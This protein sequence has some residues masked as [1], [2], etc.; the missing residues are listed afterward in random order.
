LTGDKAAVLIDNWYLQKEVLG[1]IPGQYEKFKLDY[2]RFS[3][4]LCRNIN[5][6]RFRSYVYDVDIDSNKTIMASIRKRNSFETRLGKLQESDRGI[7]QKKV[8]ILLAIDMIKLALKNKIQHIVLITGDGDFVPAVEYVKEEG[9]KVHL[10]HAG[11]S[12]D[13]ELSQACDTSAAIDNTVIVEY[14]E[15]SHY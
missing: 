5:A 12:Y 13:N 6:E 14:R 10:R 3:D 7:K 8:D 9:V 1:N 2:E 15:N 11:T 4:L